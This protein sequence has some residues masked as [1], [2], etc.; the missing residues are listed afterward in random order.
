MLT[1]VSHSKEPTPAENGRRTVFPFLVTVTSGS[2]Y[3]M[4]PLRADAR[5]II[6]EDN[7]MY[8]RHKQNPLP[9]ANIAASWRHAPVSSTTIVAPCEP[10][11]GRLRP[12]KS[13]T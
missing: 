11:G 1:E 2:C 8:S 4:A 5:I 7:Q 9:A 6:E 3:V 10:F 13:L 12:A